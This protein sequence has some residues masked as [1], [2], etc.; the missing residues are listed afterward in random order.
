[1]FEEKKKYLPL[2]RILKKINHKDLPCVVD[3]LDDGSIDTICECV[4]NAIHTDLK[5]TK[6][7]RNYMK[8]FIKSNCSINR[9]KTI[10]NKSVPISKRK[11][12]LKLEGRGIGMLIGAIL[13][14][15]ADLI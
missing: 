8:K 13:P 12:S 2:L 9:L 15:L 11:A 7:K 6:S 3:H 14:F 10:S 5:F 4:Y 1:M